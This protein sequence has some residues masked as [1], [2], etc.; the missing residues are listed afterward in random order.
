DYCRTRMKL[1]HYGLILASALPLLAEEKKAPAVSFTELDD[2]LRIELNG[3]L[4]TEYIF[5][6]DDGFFPVFYPVMWPGA[7]AVTRK[8][9]FEEV[10]REDTD[11]PHHHSLWFAHSDVNG[12]TFWAVRSYKDRETGKM[13][14]PGHQ[15]HQGFTEIESNG[16]G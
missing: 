3:E 16:E 6:R 9:P 2:R 14:E 12:E 11:H 7:V 5:K 4:F 13:R 8:H 15:V 10:E 1:F